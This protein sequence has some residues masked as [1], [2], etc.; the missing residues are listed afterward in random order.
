M[1]YRELFDDWRM[2][3]LNYT[4]RATITPLYFM[5]LLTRGM[6]I[7]QRTTYIVREGIILDRAD[8]KQPFYVPFQLHDILQL[9]D[10]YGNTIVRSTVESL[11][12]NG[13][14]TGLRHPTPIFPNQ[15]NRTYIE[16]GFGP[17]TPRMFAF[18]N[19]KVILLPDRGD[20]LLYCL[21][22]PVFAPIA[23]TEEQ[24]KEWFADE[25]SF[26][27]KMNSEAIHPLFATYSEG[28]TGYAI[29]EHLMYNGGIEV[30]SAYKIRYEQERERAKLDALAP[31][32]SRAMEYRFAP[33]S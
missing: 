16:R 18:F 12:V 25:Y 32:G 19:D 26:E 5:R 4:E 9:Q 22:V 27:E 33:F 13:N 7:F 2:A 11:N 6:S 31:S 24:W 10:N 3:I 17:N 23:E 20:K 29:S 15:Y 30:A 28:L 21:A 1:T 14:L 8:D